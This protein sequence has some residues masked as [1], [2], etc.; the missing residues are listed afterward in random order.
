[1][2]MN[3]KGPWCALKGGRPHVTP[4]TPEALLMRLTVAR[5]RRVVK[6]DLPIEFVPQQLTSYGGLELLCRYFRLLGLHRRMR[7]AFAG[8]GLGGDYGA[9]RLVRLV[10]ALFVVGARRLGHLRYLADDPL[11]ARLCGLARL[12]TDRT[13][14]NWLKQFTQ[15]ALQ[16]LIALNSELLYEQLDRLALPRLTIDVDGTVVRTGNTVAWAFRGFS[17][18]HKKDPSY[19]PLLAHLA[20]TGHILRLK[21]RPGNVHDSKQAVAF[22]RELIDDLRAQLG[23][24]IPLE[25]R[26]DAAFCQSAVFRLLT[27]RDC[28]YAIKV[29]YWSWLPLKAIAAACRHWAPIAPGV[30]RP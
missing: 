15:E 21:N 22:L 23:R 25:F 26:M 17:P 24:R 10:T 14:A 8:Y 20:Q 7:Q 4:H 1:M 18:H 19:Y 29:G 5:L 2:R 12:P 30:T 6:A 27:A 3:Q 28:A 11:V 9:G 16:A 13:V